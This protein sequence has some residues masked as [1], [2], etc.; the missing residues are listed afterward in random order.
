MQTNP[1]FNL[2]IWKQRAEGERPDRYTVGVWADGRIKPLCH[3]QPIDQAIAT[4]RAAL[5]Q[6][7][8]SSIRLQPAAAI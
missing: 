8:Q 5:E 4:I 3:I 6:A 1:E 2:Y 7:G